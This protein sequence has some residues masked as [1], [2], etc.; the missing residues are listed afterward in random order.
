VLEL[1]TSAATTVGDLQTDGTKLE[2]SHYLK[3]DGKIDFWTITTGTKT[4]K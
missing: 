4:R 2:V 1:E 3:F